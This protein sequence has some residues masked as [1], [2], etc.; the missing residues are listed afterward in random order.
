M[1]ITAML[2]RTYTPGTVTKAKE[3]KGMEP[4]KV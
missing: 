2:A 3:I 4:D 1:P